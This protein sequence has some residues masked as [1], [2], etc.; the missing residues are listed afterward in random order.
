MCMYMDTVPS[1]TAHARS[2]TYMVVLKER[3]LGEFMSKD[4][5]ASV[6]TDRRSCAYHVNDAFRREQLVSAT[7]LSDLLRH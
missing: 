3:Q 6:Q 5:T 7:G 1:K 4:W 2:L